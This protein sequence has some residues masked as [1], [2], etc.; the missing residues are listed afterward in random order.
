M[1]H[2][3]ETVADYHVKCPHLSVVKLLKN[4]LVNFNQLNNRLKP[5]NNHLLCCHQPVTQSLDNETI[6][7]HTTYIV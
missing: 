7:C 4:S 6:S 2:R 5:L 3:R 1:A